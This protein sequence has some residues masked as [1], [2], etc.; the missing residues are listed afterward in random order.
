LLA[1]F[2]RIV[3]MIHRRRFLATVARAA[4]AGSVG[5]A[6]A[7]DFSA[8]PFKFIVTVSAGGGADSVARLVGA[9]L[10]AI[11]NQP[12][13]VENRLGATG[14]IGAEAVAKSP[15]DGTTALFASTSFIQAP[16][17]FPDA[18]YNIE[19]D[20]A[21]VSQ[22]VRLAVVLVVG[23]DSPYRTL[24]DYL[25]AARQDGKSINY[26]S[27]GIGSSMHIYGETLAKDG[28]A[29]LVH[30]PYRGEAPS[31]TDTVA[32]HLDSSFISVA[33]GAP[34]IASGKL[35]PLAVIGKA[36]SPV[37]PDV[38]CFAELGFSRLDLL[39]W[40]GV[41]VPAAVPKPVIA[42]MSADIA[43]VVRQPD[44]AATIRDGGNVPIGSTPEEFGELVRGDFAKW[45][46]LVQ[47]AGIKP[48][49]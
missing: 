49:P 35:R 14:M 13:V 1:V 48:T 26:G 41:L 16:A 20:F 34:L 37:L 2:K 11:W 22:V 29:R 24:Q 6:S 47:E 42:K 43:A 45:K 15:A 9:K 7:Q 10:A 23:A 40:Y 17:L 4:A 3:D 28:R 46:Q 32:G 44:V 21:P 19:Q 38:P 18:L 33:S 39:G 25:T 8:R 30:V 36:R 27:I 5:R 31:I 12:V